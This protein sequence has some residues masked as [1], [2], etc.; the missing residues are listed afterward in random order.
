MRKSIWASLF[1]A[2]VLVG[3][4]DP[5][6]DTSSDSALKSSV[7]QVRNS[8]PEDQRPAF[9]ESLKVL[10]F[11]QINMKDVLAA[12]ATEGALLQPKIMGA[13]EG[14]TAKEVISE[15]DRIKSERQAKEREQALAE[16]GELETKKLEAEK[17]GSELKNI[18][19]LR[20]RFYVSKS[21]FMDEP[22]IELTVRNDTQVPISRIYFD[23]VLA[24]P[25]RS[26][27]W[28]KDDFNYSISGGLEPGE[29]QTWRLAPNSFSVWGKKDYPSD[30]VLTVTV[31]RADGADGEPIAQTIGFG[32]KE[33]ARLADL[34]SKFQGEGASLHESGAE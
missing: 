17:A 20:S 11:S 25:G 8:L 16:I 18:E 7:S 12:G 5:K 13:L 9:D 32:E 23:A 19:V 14:K 6:I 30:S 10:A 21:Q 15:A 33:A 29:E 1:V 24:S 28:V 31:I 3:C 4:S 22:I 27:P 34:K 2:T 26:V